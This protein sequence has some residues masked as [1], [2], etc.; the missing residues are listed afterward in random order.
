M[1]KL[2]FFISLVVTASLVY[3]LNNPIPIDPQ[4]PPLGKVL[5][6]FTGFW[7]NGEN[8]NIQKTDEIE[9]LDI[10]DVQ[11][12]VKVAYDDK[13]VPHIF[14]ENQLDAQMVLGYIE[15][16]HRLWQMDFSTR[17]TS[18]RL[19][20]VLGEL[21]VN[22]D[23]GKRRKG[24][25]FAAENT[26][27]TWKANPES[28]A[29]VEA[30]TKGVN[31]YINQL[32]TAEYPVEYKILDFKP[33]PWSPLKTAIFLKAMAETL[34][35]REVDLESTNALNTFG[36]EKFDFIY[37]ER[38]I[39]E[40]PIIPKST[41]W[42]FEPIP[43]I[44]KTAEP[45]IGA[46]FHEPFQK[47]EEFVGSNNW[48]VSGSKTASGHPILC[49][50][51]HLSLTLPAIWFEVQIHTPETNVYGVS[52]PG[53]PGVTIGFNE[54][55]AWGFTNVGHDVM[56]WY[57]IKWANAEKTKYH[58][59]GKILD[60]EIK[61]ETIKVKGHPD[62]LDTVRYTH[63]GPVSYESKEH[64]YQ[65]LALRWV[66]HD[67]EGNE[68]EAFKGINYAKNFDEYYDGLR[69][70]DNPAQNI[71]FAS[72]DGDIA[73]KVQGKLPLKAEE[74]GRFVQDGS[75]SASAWKGFIPFEQTPFAKNPEEGF[76]GSAN[77][78]SADTT[79]PYYYN[80]GF[81]DFRGRSLNRKLA[82]MNNITI[83]DM[84]DLQANNFSVKAE[85]ALPLFLSYLENENLTAEEK[86]LVDIL[87][88]W[89]YNYDKNKTAP[90]IFNNWYSEFYKKTWD[91]IYALDKDDFPILY[92][93]S[94][95]TIELIDKTPNS[96]LFDHKETAEKET[97][98]EIVMMSFKEM[99]KKSK[100][101]KKDGKYV[102]WEKHRNIRLP[103]MIKSLK[104]FR[105]DYI[106][107][108]GYGDVLN[109]FTSRGGGAFGPSWRMIV[110]LGDEVKAYGVYPA[111]QSGNPGSPF[112][113]SMVKTWASG[114][115][116]ELIFLKDKN[117]KNDRILFAQ[118][119]K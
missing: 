84:K 88:K 3:F 11:A 25:L 64:P 49:N 66:A 32:S 111:G 13:M 50:D 57:R 112:Y 28:F 26:L 22:Y 48:T 69:T 44:E 61:I 21:T 62:V 19:S 9:S 81:E 37:P 83:Q 74:Q 33:E 63:W 38:S 118:E 105:S 54:N 65:D 68:L 101:W 71:A 104:G 5:N 60:A 15:A 43:E 119:F 46:I 45:S 1:N 2:K 87:K 36:R 98:K 47:P 20:E 59:D 16:Q 103:H 90:I 93:E 78:F 7:Q 31:A 67:G 52:L 10:L 89:D 102:S 39:K 72:R 53:S 77:Q 42:D 94:W 17:A 109:A 115:Y 100:D 116:Y 82:S 91:E 56:D 73:L 113:D 4:V 6:P 34:S 86:E 14:A 96:E 97:A 108:G 80:G 107:A 55:I 75:T 85:E 79:Y 70:F 106:S 27:K 29:M 40:S 8:A 95:R 24:L 58:F 12:P 30:Y 51:P 18:G 110:E 99:V 41:E 117:E 23:K 35:S 76:I 114:D 92:P